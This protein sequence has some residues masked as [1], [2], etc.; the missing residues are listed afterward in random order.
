L[1]FV[2]LARS[3]DLRVGIIGL[4]TSHAVEFTK[5]L[6]DPKN[7]AHI[8]GARVVAAFPGGSADI[9]SSADRV[10]QYT[11]T[12]RDQ[13][14]VEIV[15]DIPA[16][17]ARVD[18]VLLLSV[19][20]RPHLEQIRPVIAA[21][22]PVFIDKPLA[23]SLKD[24]RE[25]Y[26][27]CAEARVPC[28]SASALR[29]YPGIQAMKTTA[30]EIIGVEAFAPATL[31]PHHPDLYWYAIH[32][33]EILY[34][35][36]G[37]GCRWVQRTF[38]DDQDV[39]VAQWSDGRTATLR[40]TRKGPHLY[41]ATV[42]GSKSVRLSEPVQGALY[43]GLVTEIVRFFQTG[44]PPVSPEETLEMFVFMDAAQLSR[45]R[46]GARVELGSVR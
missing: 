17:L 37:P 29:F 15:A 20:G 33:V 23:A 34:T 41:G 19:D 9:P 12:L 44:R 45:Q 38:T 18:A 4:D 21:R 13:W 10:P 2:A 24:A 25:I 16:L 36:M 35:L 42:Y 43:Q 32:G 14:Q 22:K 28:F 39:I 6:N 30:G 46:D 5:L 11:A 40:G 31:E 8:A 7:P 27:L 26:R 1:F 3:D